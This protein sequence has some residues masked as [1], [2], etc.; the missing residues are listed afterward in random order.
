MRDEVQTFDNSD[1]IKDIELETKDIRQIIQ[2]REQNNKVVTLK[3]K[4]TYVL[5]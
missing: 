4:D 3:Y 1:D 2:G 5:V